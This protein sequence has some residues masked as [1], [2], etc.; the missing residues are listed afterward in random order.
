MSSQRPLSVRCHEHEAPQSLQLAGVPC[1]GSGTGADLSC[2]TTCIT[3]GGSGSRSG[4]CT[5]SSQPASHATVCNGTGRSLAPSLEPQAMHTAAFTD[6]TLLSL[7]Q[8]P[9]DPKR[10]FADVSGP[11]GSP[12]MAIGGEATAE[13]R[14]RLLAVGRRGCQRARQRCEP[15][16]HP[17]GRRPRAARAD[18]PGRC[19]DILRNCGLPGGQPGRHRDSD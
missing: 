13:P 7:R 14:V 5:A 17:A 18:G 2:S 16:R 1:A 12:T 15:A 6:S 3:S 4:K 11:A 9:Y 10:R 19:A 8:S